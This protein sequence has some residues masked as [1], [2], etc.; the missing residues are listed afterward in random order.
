MLREGHRGI[1]AQDATHRAGHRADD[2]LG[3]GSGGDERGAVLVEPRALAF[4]YFDVFDAI[5]ELGIFHALPR[6][7]AWRAALA[8][9]PS[10]IAAV[11]PDYPARLHAVLAADD[12]MLLRRDRFETVRDLDHAAVF[13]ARGS[14]GTS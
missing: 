1:D 6:V 2:V 11:A 9:R 5:T 12:A 8:A 14:A 10:V 7:Q 3:G 4:R 13:A